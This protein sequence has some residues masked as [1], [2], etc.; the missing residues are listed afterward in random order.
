MEVTE[1]SLSQDTSARKILFD[2]TGD[3]SSQDEDS[4]NGEGE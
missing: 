3:L 4:E 2:K 1:D